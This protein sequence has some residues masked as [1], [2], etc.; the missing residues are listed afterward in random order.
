MVDLLSESFTADHKPLLGES[1]EVRG[2]FFGCGFNSGGM[3]MSK[4]VS[5]CTYLHIP[6]CMTSYPCD[7][8]VLKFIHVL[9]L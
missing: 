8:V 5:L 2:F 7:Y 4:S 1:P 3:M 6:E 9:S